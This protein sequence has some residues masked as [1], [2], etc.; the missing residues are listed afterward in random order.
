LFSLGVL[1][2]K[3]ELSDELMKFSECDQGKVSC[4]V[5]LGGSIGTLVAMCVASVYL[6]IGLAWHFRLFDLTQLHRG[7]QLHLLAFNSLLLAGLLWGVVIHY[8]EAVNLIS[9]PTTK[10]ATI[11]LD[12]S[13]WL[14]VGAM[15]ALLPCI[16]YAWKQWKWSIPSSCVRES[17]RRTRH[18]IACKARSKRR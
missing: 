5:L 17:T 3:S 18:W 4:H 12:I 9:D 11:E 6:L 8:P 16:A 15:A 14:C 1:G 13:L 10:D 7:V 2:V